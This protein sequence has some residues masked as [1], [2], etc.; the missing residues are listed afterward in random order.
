MKQTPLPEKT[1]VSPGVK[2][3]RDF[4]A[5]KPDAPIY[6]TEFGFYVM[7]K[8]KAEGHLP[9]D[10]GW[11]EWAE[12]FGWD[13][14][15]RHHLNCC[16]WCEAGFEPVFETKVVKDLG[17]CELEQ[18]FAGRIVKYFKNRRS[19][20][21]PDYVDH[22]V[23]DMK[24]WEENCLWRMDPATPS[25][26]ENQTRAIEAAAGA[27]DQGKFVV[28]NLVGGY[29]Y[30]RSLAGPEDLMYMFYEQPEL[31]HACMKA[32]FDLAD[33]F[34]TRAQTAG[35]NIDEIFLAEDICYNHGFLISPDMVREFLFPYYQQLI[36][37][38]RS[39]QPDKN[40]PVKL[41]VDTDGFCDPAI[42][43][44][45]EIGLNFMSPFEAASNCDVV[46]TGQE[47]PD[48]LISGGFDKRILAAGR[49][50]IDREVARILPVMKKRG[51]YYPTCDHG[52]PEEV[53]FEDYVH[54]R[55]RLL[56]FA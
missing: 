1:P 56:E 23:K 52:V 40:A 53:K 8:W 28:A 19:G 17:D 7:D 32:W 37:N 11:G 44:Y 29:M 34:Y 13:E 4:Y 21:M 46:R 54:F 15:A 35:L 41:Q 14:G 12:L 9:K 42:K 45:R 38:V 26:V 5:M 43:L 31:I 22:P 24:T 16:G 39:R 47:Y 51:G 36:A 6:M 10:S 27:A 25:R 48:L 55:K 33:S 50:A 18:D 2:K 49:D 30:L 20:F 3:Y